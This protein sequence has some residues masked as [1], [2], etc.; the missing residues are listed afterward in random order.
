MPEGINEKDIVI[1]TKQK[2]E[3][4][5]SNYSPAIK[6]LAW[7]NQELTEALP[8]IIDWFDNNINFIA[9]IKTP[10]DKEL[11]EFFGYGAN[12][13]ADVQIVA[14]IPTTA[15]TAHAVDLKDVIA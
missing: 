6:G 1:N 12:T 4:T 10:T 13:L 5:E 15:K 11:L 7:E 9:D 3:Y 2:G 8:E 14:A